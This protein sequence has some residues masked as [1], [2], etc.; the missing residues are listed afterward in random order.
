MGSGFSK[1]K[2]QAKMMQAQM[3]QMRQD[4]AKQMAE[5]SSGGGLVSVIVNGEKEIQKITIKP[6]CVN[7][8]DIEG[9]QDLILAA[10]ADALSK[11]P[12]Q[13]NPLAGGQF[14]FL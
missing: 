2:K 14:P 4:L 12:E 10:H 7:P 5:G 3:G 8:N 13:E 11:L 1:M 9:L 6:E